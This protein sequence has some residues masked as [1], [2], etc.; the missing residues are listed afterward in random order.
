MVRDIA[1]IKGPKK[2]RHAYARKGS[3]EETLA[4]AAPRETALKS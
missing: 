3:Y 1:T 4:A 2:A